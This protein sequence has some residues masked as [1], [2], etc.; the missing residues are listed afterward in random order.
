ME[1]RGWGAVVMGDGFYN[2]FGNGMMGGVAGDTACW[3]TSG[4]KLARGSRGGEEGVRVRR[5]I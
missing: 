3:G 5:G 1:V 4:S 2:N